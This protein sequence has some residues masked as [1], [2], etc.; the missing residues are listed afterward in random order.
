MDELVFSLA[1]VF[2]CIL[3]YSIFTP[4]EKEFHFL[5]FLVGYAGIANGLALIFQDTNL[6]RFI[7]AVIIVVMI[8]YF[9][10]L[11]KKVVVK[12]RKR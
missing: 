2:F 9:I 11:N 4:N 12:R 1:L 8:A 7:G 10:I 6:I 3:M 5:W